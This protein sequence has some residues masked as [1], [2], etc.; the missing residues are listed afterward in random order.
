[1]KA[2][3]TGICGQDGVCLSRLLLSKGYEVFG[4]ARRGSSPHDPRIRLHFGDLTDPSAL[5]HALSEAQ[6]TE[7][8]NLGAQSHVGASFQT[9]DYTMRVTGLPIITILEYVRLSAPNVRVYQA[10]TS[11]LF[12][13]EAP[14]QSEYTAFSPRSP[15]A[16]AK[17]AAHHTTRIYRNAYGLYACAGILFNHEAEG[18]RP[19]AFVTRKISQGVARIKKGISNELVLGNLNAVRD[20]G[21]AEDYVR[22]MWLM[23]QKGGIPRDYVVATGKAHSVGD[24]ASE[25]F[26]HVGLDWKD[27]VKT[28]V[29]LQRPSEVPHLLG[30]ASLARRELGWEPVV[31]FEELVHR[32]VDYDMEHT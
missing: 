3:I 9:P 22:A 15:Y 16:V 29:A 28:D 30:D 12:G 10:S 7:I 19:P 6:P 13:D 21:H 24:F 5:L 14:P 4:F 25:A 18:L 26:R 23:L 20:W 8:Y 2:F 17:L 11:E 31:E 27:Y 1:M 32:M